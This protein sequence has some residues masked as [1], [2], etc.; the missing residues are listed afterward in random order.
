MKNHFGA[1]RLTMYVAV[2][3][4]IALVLYIM[5]AA[6]GGLGGQQ[7][8]A[9]M[10]IALVLAAMLYLWLPQLKA[11][12]TIAGR[13]RAEYPSE[14]QPRVLAA[15]NRLKSKEL[16]YVFTKVLDDAKGSPAEVEKLCGIAESTGPKAFLEDQ[17]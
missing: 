1:K 10:G 4:L 7:L 16:D 6:R 17:W 13:I 9:G 8:C 11:E 2:P 15:Y 3:A 12:K 5:W 14:S